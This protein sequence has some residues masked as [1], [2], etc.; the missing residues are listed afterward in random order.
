MSSNTFF[1][2]NMC[3]HQQQ[4]IQ[5]LMYM[6][7]R[8]TLWISGFGW[9]VSWGPESCFKVFRLSSVLP[10][11]CLDLLCSSLK[12]NNCEY[13]SQN[14][15]TSATNILQTSV[16]EYWYLYK[17]TVYWQLMLSKQHQP[18]NLPP[19]KKIPTKKP[20]LLITIRQFFF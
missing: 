1:L 6:V 5:F 19:P 12:V 9:S 15:N 10:L 18:I 3:I 20:Y 17:I 14:I 8:P 4:S 2:L 11:E 7:H 13:K 16:V